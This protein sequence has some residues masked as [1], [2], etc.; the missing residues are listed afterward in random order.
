MQQTPINLGQNGDLLAL[1][2]RDASRIVE[3]GCSGGG[4]A[5]EY[6]KIN[7]RCEYIGIEINGQYAEVARTHCTRVIVDD[8]EH[9]SDAAFESIASC[10]CWIF[11]DVLEHLYDP[12]ALLRRIRATIPPQSSV[13]ACI[14]NAQ[15]WTLQAKLNCGAF[16]YEDKGLLDRTHI[17]WF[18]RATIDELFASSGFAIVDGICRILDEPYR[19]AALAGI[20]A[21][22]EKIGTNPEQAATDATPLQYVIRAMPV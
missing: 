9:M 15:H 13:L 11:G 10:S 19:D 5:R 21:F 17:R 2:P 6:L 7:P 18:T 22:A 8:I 4:L 12:W 16:R 20:R 3:V 1:I 14:P